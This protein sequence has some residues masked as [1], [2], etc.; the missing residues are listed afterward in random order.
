MCIHNTLPKR[1]VESGSL[2]PSHPLEEIDDKCDSQCL[3][4]PW[5]MFRQEM[6]DKVV[7]N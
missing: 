4:E 5:L 7:G 3:V 1:K 2:D 6:A